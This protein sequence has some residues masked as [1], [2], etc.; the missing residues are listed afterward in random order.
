M[1]KTETDNLIL[2]QQAALFFNNIIVKS[3][4]AQPP[5]GRANTATWTVIRFIKS[6]VGL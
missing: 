5:A 6:R 1:S 3:A 2:Y 4:I